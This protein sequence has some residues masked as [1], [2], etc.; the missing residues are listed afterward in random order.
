MKRSECCARPAPQPSMKSSPRPA[1]RRSATQWSRTSGG[2]C[3]WKLSSG[4]LWGPSD[5]GPRFR[6]MRPAGI[7]RR[8]AAAA[9]WRSSRRPSD[10]LGRR[11]ARRHRRVLTSGRTAALGPGAA[12]CPWPVDT[13]TFTSSR[14]TRSPTRVPIIATPASGNF[15]WLPRAACRPGRGRSAYQKCRS[16]RAVTSSVDRC[17]AEQEFP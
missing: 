5:V 9:S 14:T 6:A 17:R 15:T 1:S 12:W 2:D 16:C 3:W 11:R 10:K 13:P 4:L 8:T 7:S